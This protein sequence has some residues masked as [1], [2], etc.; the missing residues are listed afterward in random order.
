M[1]YNDF[2]NKI[3]KKLPRDVPSLQHKF[4]NPFKTVVSKHLLQIQN[5]GDMTWQ[6]Q[7][8]ILYI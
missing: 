7:H 1:I 2:V 8:F 5:E 6:D 3:N 4:M